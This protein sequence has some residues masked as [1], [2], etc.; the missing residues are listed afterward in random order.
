MGEGG[1]EAVAWID[2]EQTP[3][4]RLVAMTT[5]KCVMMVEEGAEDNE[6]GLHILVSLGESS[7]L[8]SGKS[9]LLCE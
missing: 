1:S 3:G 4:L 7:L 8:I 9:Q 5:L 6:K 2:D